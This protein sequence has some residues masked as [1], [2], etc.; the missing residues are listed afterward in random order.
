MCQRTS[1]LSKRQRSRPFFISL[2]TFLTGVQASAI[3]R[4]MWWPQPSRP[5]TKRKRRFSEKAVFLTTTVA[6]AAAATAD[7]NE[8]ETQASSARRIVVIEGNKFLWQGTRFWLA[9]C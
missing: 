9:I 6:S 7:V 3:A 8:Q 2:L 1:L 4:T 5:A